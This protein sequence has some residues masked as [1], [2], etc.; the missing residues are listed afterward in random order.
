MYIYMYIYRCK[1]A[2][3]RPGMHRFAVASGAS[4]SGANRGGVPSASGRFAWRGR[5][6]ATRHNLF[7]QFVI[8]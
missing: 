1:Y 8:V 2:T 4:R 3:V 5:L 6:W 7:I